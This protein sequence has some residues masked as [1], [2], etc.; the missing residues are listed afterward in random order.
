M[1]RKQPELDDAFALKT[2]EDS[3]ALYSKW[4]ATYDTGFVVEMDY[5]LPRRVAEIFAELTDGHG[6][7]LDVGAGT[8]LVAEA[9]AGIFRADIDALDIS[10]EMLEVAAGKSLYRMTILGDLTRSLDIPNQTYRAVISSGTFTHGHVGPDGLDE[11][12]RVAGSGALFVVA[13]NAE[14]YVAKG[15]EAKF[16]SMNADT[17]GMEIRTVRNYGDRADGEHRDDLA[18][19]VVFW[20]R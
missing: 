3:V 15:F 7:V 16:A 19:V 10:A 2:P 4:S 9:L 5:Q 17:R 8:G 11:L 13:V 18:N 6:P 20:K 14:H 12:L 1:P